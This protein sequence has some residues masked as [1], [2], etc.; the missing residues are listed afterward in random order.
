MWAVSENSS[1]P[2]VTQAGY[3]LSLYRAQNG[4]STCAWLM[5]RLD[6]LAPPLE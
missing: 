4:V 6:R 5:E 3:G 1:P 2:L